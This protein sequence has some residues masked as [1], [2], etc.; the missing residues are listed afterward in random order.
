MT[1]QAA[2]SVEK[3][4]DLHSQQFSVSTV[5]NECK[6]QAVHGT[7]RDSYNIT[8][9]VEAMEYATFSGVPAWGA[10]A[11]AVCVWG[12]AASHRP[13]L[14][15]RTLCAAPRQ[16]AAGSSSPAVPS[17]CSRMCVCVRGCVHRH[18]AVPRAQPLL[19]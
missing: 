17:H 18:P 5:G 4:R 8:P 6:W 10:R 12:G 2:L 9:C 19:G 13:L 3:Y 16:R 1:G 15:A 11:L 14:A 7:S